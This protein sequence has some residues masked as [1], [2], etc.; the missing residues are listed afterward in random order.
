M[1]YESHDH[2]LFQQVGL[3]DTFGAIGNYNLFMKCEAPNKTAFRT[4]P[5]GYSFRMCRRNEL[6]VWK[7]IV[8]KEQYAEHVADYY[9]RVY[10]KAED[11]FFRR[12]TFV[13]DANDKPVATSFIWLSYG[14]INTIA[15]LRVLPEYEGN[16]LGRALLSE[17]LRMTQY[18]VYLHT[19]P[20][21]ICAVKL[22]SDFGFRL[23]ESQVIGY[24]QNNLAESLPYMQ[25]V[26]NGADFARLQFVDADY[27]LHQVA[28]TSELSE[29]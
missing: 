23:I 9:N 19:Q 6:K 29:F 17:I 11:E 16:G 2:H 28:L 7:R 18:P 20:T 4:L 25:K 22:Y 8:A 13:C 14:K 26:M 15:W 12:C 10:A 1:A 3:A 27:Y 24:R 21:S 5:F